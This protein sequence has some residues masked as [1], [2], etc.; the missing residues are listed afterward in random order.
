[1]AGII[2]LQNSGVKVLLFARKQNLDRLEHTI[3]GMRKF[4][5]SGHCLGNVPKG[6]DHFGPKVGDPEKRRVKQ[7]I[8]VNE[9]GKKL[10]LAWEWKSKG[11]SDTIIIK[12]IMNSESH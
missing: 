7:E 1:L 12:N 3:P 4:V 5:K 6:Y 8:L 10:K 2:W 11:M 9:D